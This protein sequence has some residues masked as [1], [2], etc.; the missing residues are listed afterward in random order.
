MYSFFPIQNHPLG[1]YYWS[2][3]ETFLKAKLY[4]VSAELGALFICLRLQDLNLKIFSLISLWI[5][6]F[7]Y[8]SETIMFLHQIFYQGLKARIAS[9]PTLVLGKYPLFCYLCSSVVTFL[10]YSTLTS[11]LCSLGVQPTSLTSCCPCWTSTKS[12][13]GTT[14]IA[15][16]SW[17]TAN[18]IG[19]LTS[20]WS[21]MRPS[22]TVRKGLWRPSSP[23]PCSR[24]THLSH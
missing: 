2:Y 20:C 18:R 9:W 1:W 17:L 8:F 15:Y 10:N 14:S 16:R 11:V 19:T 6:F 22:L 4:S 12:L 23:T 24:L 13:W 7:L 3:K 21:S 5:F